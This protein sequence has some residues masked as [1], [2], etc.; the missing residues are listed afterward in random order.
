M[1]SAWQKAAHRN[2][3]YVFSGHTWNM[4]AEAKWLLS[5]LRKPVIKHERVNILAGDRAWTLEKVKM[6]TTQDAATFRRGRLL[7]LLTLMPVSAFAYVDPGSGMLLWQGLLAL[8]GAV[9]VFA[10]N[11][12]EAIKRLLARFK[13]K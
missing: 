10:R 13:R 1:T 7:I 2:V 3:F 11:P 12:V 9:I 5:Q 8:V 6:T 4:C